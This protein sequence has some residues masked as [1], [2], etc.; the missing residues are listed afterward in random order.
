MSLSIIVAMAENGVI[1]RNGGLPWHLASDLKLF[2]DFTMGHTLLMGRKTFDEV[3]KPLPGRRTILITRQEDFRPPGVS[4]AHSMDEALRLLPEG[5]ETFVVGGSQI[6]AQTLP[7]ATR[8]YLTLVKANVDG[9]T[10]FPAL[11]FEDWTEVSRKDYLADERN[12][13][14]FTFKLFERRIS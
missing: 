9:D 8:L 14:P 5:E 11:N 1:G 10:W 6:Y 4:I 2:K 13:Y 3:G 7:L 12:D